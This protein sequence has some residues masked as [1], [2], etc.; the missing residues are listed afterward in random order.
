MGFV[1]PSAP[2]P[3][4]SCVENQCSY[5][6]PGLCLAT[7]SYCTDCV[8]GHH[9]TLT[10]NKCDC[11]VGYFDDGSNS[12]CAQCDSKC[13]TCVGSAVNCEACKTNNHRIKDG[14]NNCVCESHYF[15]DGTDVCKVCSHKCQACETSF[16]NCISCQ[17]TDRGTAPSCLCL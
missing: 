17:G 6:C 15:D 1:E 9:R 8:P 3:D 12:V 16:D 14:S 7:S 5:T 2:V 4:F 13:E 10:A 11:D